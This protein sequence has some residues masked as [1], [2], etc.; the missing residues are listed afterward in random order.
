ME[1]EIAR[2]A[3]PNEL[4]NSS[5]L[6]TTIVS[7]NNCVVGVTFFPIFAGLDTIV[8]YGMHSIVDVYII[9]QIQETLGAPKPEIG[10]SSLFGI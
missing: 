2:V 6:E 3:C 9:G 8:L 10:N 7:T 4:V 5:L 1:I